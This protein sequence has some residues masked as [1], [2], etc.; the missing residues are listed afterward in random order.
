MSPTRPDARALSTF[1][2]IR[3]NGD[4]DLLLSNVALLYYGEGLTQ[5]EIAKRLKVSRATIVNMLREGRERGIVEIRVDGKHLTSSTLSRALKEKYGL[6]DVYVALNGEPDTGPQDRAFVL[7]QTA[8][9]AAAAV[10]DLV[11]PGDRV[12]VA[13]GETIMAVAGAMSAA[14]VDDV[15]VCQ[16]IG[17]MISERV[18]A[19]ENC[20]ILIANKLGAKCFTLHAPAL[21]SSEELANTIRKEPA[22]RSQMERLTDLD[23]TIAGIGDMSPDTHLAVADMATIAELDAARTAG[24]VGILCCRFIDADGNSLD[25]PPQRRVIAADVGHLRTA[26]KKLLVVCGMERAQAARAAINGGLVTHLCVDQD[27][28]ERL[29]ELD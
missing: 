28:G 22:I 19:S 23:M 17:S 6:G 24:G 12:G 5:S 20:T 15:E 14:H 21:M 4:K 13:W 8:R 18:P 7:P 10:A 3:T 25:L 16:L 27:L 9:V 29:L 11:E 26:R 1:S 2:Q